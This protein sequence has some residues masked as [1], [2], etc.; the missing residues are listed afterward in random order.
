[1]Y[2][3][4]PRQILQEIIEETRKISAEQTA[5]RLTKFGNES[6]K[7]IRKVLNN[8]QNHTKVSCKLHFMITYDMYL[9]W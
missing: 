4:K 1:M 6:V 9:Q 3:I 8:I 5:C 7:I 2:Q